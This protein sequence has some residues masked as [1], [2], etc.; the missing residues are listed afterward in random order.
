MRFITAMYVEQVPALGGMEQLNKKWVVVSEVGLK[1]LLSFLFL[2]LL[3]E[4]S[5][6]H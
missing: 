4:N 6:G 3:N 2:I 1:F 5:N